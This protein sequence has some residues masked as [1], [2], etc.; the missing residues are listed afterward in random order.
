MTSIDLCAILRQDTEQFCSNSN[1]ATRARWLQRLCDLL[2]PIVG[3]Y[4]PDEQDSVPTI[5]SRLS[6]T[7][8]ERWFNAQKILR[9]AQFDSLDG[10]LII[11]INSW[12]NNLHS[13]FDAESMLVPPNPESA[14]TSEAKLYYLLE[15]LRI[16]EGNKE[17]SA[18]MRVIRKRFYLVSFYLR[19]DAAGYGDLRRSKNRINHLNGEYGKIYHDWAQSAGG[20]GALFLLA[21]VSDSSYKNIAVQDRQ[22]IIA[23]NQRHGLSTAIGQHCLSPL[24]DQL[25]N[26]LQSKAT[27]GIST[28]AFAKPALSVR[29]QNNQTR[30]NVRAK[31][32][33]EVRR[34][35]TVGPQ[36]TPQPQS[37][38][39]DKHRTQL[40]ISDNDST[41]TP[42]VFN[43][44]ATDL[45]VCRTEHTNMSTTRA[46]VQPVAPENITGELR[47]DQ[48]ALTLSQMHQNPAACSAAS[49]ENMTQYSCNPMNVV[50][51]YGVS[52][53]DQG[54][55]P[56]IL[57]PTI[58]AGTEDASTTFNSSTQTQSS[59]DPS[60]QLYIGN[61]P[62]FLDP[63]A[64]THIENTF[65]FSNSP[66]Q[67][68]TENASAFS[69]P[70]RTQKQND[71]D[72]IRYDDNSH[73]ENS[74]F[75]LPSPRSELGHIF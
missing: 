74:Q 49:L 62:D 30:K 75:G 17:I 72:C 31:R 37:A 26:I 46:A 68:R 66:T 48:A 7:K 15:A 56:V 58:Y 29:M 60:V 9:E 61:I 33:G 44:N 39:T 27:L 28:I 5:L 2:L 11:L 8:K 53:S 19:A 71:P 54:N 12:K 45:A 23:G 16:L 70:T 1:D 4:W 35:R 6:P 22:E 43:R 13:F 55:A 42:N 57:T 20:Y 34:N 63:S 41:V 65:P 64:Q 32:K 38:P 51:R 36:A 73:N 3:E 69:H 10:T 52:S 40:Q 18:T 50:N 25:V 14:P 59:F 24:A 67:V 47:E 21:D